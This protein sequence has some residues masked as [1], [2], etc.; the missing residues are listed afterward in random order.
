MMVS[1][2]WAAAAGMVQMQHQDC[3]HSLEP[4]VA[5]WDT[6]VRRH[7]CVPAEGTDNGTC[8]QIASDSLVRGVAA[9]HCM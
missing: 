3:E 6:R 2:G 8:R 7:V 4:G 1:A 9:E 5:M